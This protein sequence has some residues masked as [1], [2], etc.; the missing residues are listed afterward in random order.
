MIGDDYDLAPPSVRLAGLVDDVGDLRLSPPSGNSRVRNPVPKRLLIIPNVESVAS[1]G[2]PRLELELGGRRDAGARL[3]I[4]L[5]FM[6][7]LFLL[8]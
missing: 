8:A 7:G 4:R 5:M 2:A 1:A 6:I 3:T